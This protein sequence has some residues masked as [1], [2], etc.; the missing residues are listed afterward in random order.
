MRHEATTCDR[1]GHEGRDYKGW[2]ELRGDN[3]LPMLK[4]RRGADGSSD[5]IADLC[6]NCVKGFAEWWAARKATP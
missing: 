3:R 1:C 4:Q 2:A 6:P 5:F